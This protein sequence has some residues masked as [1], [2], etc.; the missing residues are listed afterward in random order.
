MRRLLPVLALLALAG[1]AQ[2]RGLLLPV[3]KNA[4]PLAMLS[5]QVT[6]A[7]EDQVAITHVEQ[8]FRNQTDRQLEATYL[9]PV[10][11]GASVN[12]CTVGVGGKEAH[13][14]HLEAGKARDIFASIV[15]RTQDPGLREYL[16]NDLFR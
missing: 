13:G 4:P 15:R 5:H 8:T 16:G 6:V 10:P 14:E 7:I 2:A 9:F 12:K 11:K 1:P 3:G